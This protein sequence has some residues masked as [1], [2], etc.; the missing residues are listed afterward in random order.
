MEF[1]KKEKY[2]TIVDTGWRREDIF[3]AMHRI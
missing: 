1:E 2:P 3:D